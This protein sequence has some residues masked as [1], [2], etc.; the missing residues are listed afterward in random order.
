MA[1]LWVTRQA[2]IRNRL[3]RRGVAH[4]LAHARPDPRIAVESAHPDGDRIGMAGMRPN[5]DEPQMPQNHFSPPLSGFH[6]RSV[7]SPETIRKAPSAGWALA[8]AA[9]PLRR[10]QRLQWQ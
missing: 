2:V 6:T 1:A 3:P 9:P 5:T 8:D 7:S 10:W 4:E